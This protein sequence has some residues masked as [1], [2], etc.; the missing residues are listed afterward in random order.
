MAVKPNQFVDGRQYV[1]AAAQ[2]APRVGTAPAHRAAQKAPAKQGF[3]GRIATGIKETI[4]GPSV[5][6]AQTQRANS[7]NAVYQRPGAEPYSNTAR[8][9]LQALHTGNL[10]TNSVR[11]VTGNISRTPVS[12]EALD[13]FLQHVIGENQ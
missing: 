4:L 10:A 13:A 6:A 1:R 12:D 9:N 5:P 2:P 7:A 3:L 11:A 8:R